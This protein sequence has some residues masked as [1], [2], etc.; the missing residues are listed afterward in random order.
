MSDYWRLISNTEKATR[1]EPLNDLAPAW[2]LSL[3]VTLDAL[4]DMYYGR[5]G[6][7]VDELLRASLNELRCSQCGSDAS[8]A[9]HEFFKEFRA[10]LHP[11]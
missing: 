11:P 6:P 1:Q 4:A 10:G 3:K 7:W 2:R 9:L 8:R 5:D